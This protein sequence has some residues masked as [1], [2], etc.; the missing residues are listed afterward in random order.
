MQYSTSAGRPRV[1]ASRRR[2]ITLWL[3]PD[4]YAPGIVNHRMSKGNVVGQA[5]DGGR[6]WDGAPLRPAHRENEGIQLDEIPIDDRVAGRC[7]RFGRL[8]RWSQQQRCTD[9]AQ[10]GDQ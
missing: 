9:T 5:L 1:R 10:A 8:W 4:V 7:N 2:L 6:V 3:D